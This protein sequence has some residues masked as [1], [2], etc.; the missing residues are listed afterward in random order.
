MP[1]AGSLM[2]DIS[3]TDD[4]ERFYEIHSDPQTNLFNSDGPMN[5]E[6]AR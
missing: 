1:H 6:K 3:K 2:P 5:L 4:F